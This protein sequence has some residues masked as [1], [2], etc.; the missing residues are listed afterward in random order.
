M[1]FGEYLPFGDLLTRFGLDEVVQT[2][3]GF[4]AGAKRTILTG[5]DGVRLLPLICYEAIFPGEVA[6]DAPQSDILVNVTN[7]TWFGDTP[8]PWQHLRQAQLRAVET[9]LPMLRAGNSGLSAVI[10]SRGRILD[11]LA[12]NAVGVL[13]A[14]LPLAKAGFMRSRHQ[15]LLAALVIAG[16][17]MMA[18]VLHAAAVR[19][20]D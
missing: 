5:P 2:P 18:L 10:D 6:A 9:G 14:A 15:G 11:G 17:A 16:L 13:D 1:P 4:S 20:L 19:R 7:D 12:L 3:G 8:G